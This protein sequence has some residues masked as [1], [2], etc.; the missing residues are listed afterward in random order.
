MIISGWKNNWC[1]STLA[2]MNYISVARAILQGS[3]FLIKESVSWTLYKETKVVYWDIESY[4]FVA[5][6]ETHDARCLFS[7]LDLLKLYAQCV[8]GIRCF[9][10]C[11][12]A[13]N[14][15]VVIRHRYLITIQPL[16]SKTWWK[17]FFYCKIE[18]NWLLT[19]KIYVHMLPVDAMTQLVSCAAKK[20]P[21]NNT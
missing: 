8:D 1:F 16:K 6:I 9:F 2:K 3:G 5:Y 21:Y 20:L 13:R 18:G 4:R 19:W 10:Y 11:L 14:K 12:Q 15:N 7:W 17:Y